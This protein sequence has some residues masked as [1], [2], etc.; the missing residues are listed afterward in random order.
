MRCATACLF[1]CGWGAQ[2]AVL[3]LEGSERGGLAERLGRP[4]WRRSF[5]WLLLN[6]KLKFLRL[7]RGRG[8]ARAAGLK[9]LK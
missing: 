3:K 2:G 8:T 9:S 7:R 6:E 5:G 1:E 4:D